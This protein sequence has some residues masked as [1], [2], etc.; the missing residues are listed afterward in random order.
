MQYTPNTNKT[1]SPGVLKSTGQQCHVP[2]PFLYPLSHLWPLLEKCYSLYSNPHLFLNTSKET[3]THI[4]THTTEEKRKAKRKDI[5][6]PATRQE[7]YKVLV[8]MHTKAQMAAK[9]AF[10][11][12]FVLSFTLD[13][14]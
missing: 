10:L 5:N 4:H 13:L 2:L 7:T 9:K 6:R 3:H 11:F 14:N 12:W 1:K 8:D